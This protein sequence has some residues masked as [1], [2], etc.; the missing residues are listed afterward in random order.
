MAEI[1]RESL[2]DV[3]A[4]RRVNEE[5]FGDSDAADLGDD[6][7]SAGKVDLSLVALCDERTVG[8]VLF[9][10]LILPE[11]VE[12]EVRA[13]ALAPLAVLPAYQRQG[14]GSALAIRGLEMSREAGYGFAV[15]LG[16]TG[17]YPRFGFAPASRFGLES[18][19]K[20]GD[21]FMALALAPGSLAGI[22]GLVKYQ[23]EFKENGC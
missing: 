19:Y 1:R 11:G 14:I 16:A 7:R 17:Y 10:R 3:A 18:E 4:I 20:A 23:P 2:E 8:H 5:A 6:L 9:S 15:V 13:T 12:T 22:E 21:H